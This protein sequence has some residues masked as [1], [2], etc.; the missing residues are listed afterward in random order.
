M[1]REKTLVIMLGEVITKLEKV[2]KVNTRLWS[3]K[4]GQ[5]C[6]Q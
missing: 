2:T 3:I 6:Q 5:Y 1:K 4:L